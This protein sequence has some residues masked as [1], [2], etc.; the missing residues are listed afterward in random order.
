MLQ[1]KEG[2]RNQENNGGPN[3]IAAWRKARGF[4]QK[5]I[6]VNGTVKIPGSGKVKFPTLRF[7]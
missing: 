5:E 2:V 3:H 1:S 4:S 7:G 6:A